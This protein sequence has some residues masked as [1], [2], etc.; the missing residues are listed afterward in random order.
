MS[1]RIF[2]CFACMS[3]LVACGDGQPLFDEGTGGGTGGGNGEELPRTVELPPGTVNTSAGRGIERYEARNDLGGGLITND[4]VSYD[5]VADTFTVD[6]LAFDG[7]N[8]YR[9]DNQVPVLNGFNVYEASVQVIDPVSGEPVGQIVPYRALVGQSTN[10]VNGSPRTSFAI[11]RTGGYADYGF[12]GFVYERNG[13]VV[14]PT[15]GQATFSGDYAGMRVFLGQGGLE[16]TTGDM[17]IDIDFDDFNANDGVKGTITNR[18]AFT[19]NGQPIPTGGD[20]QLVLPTLNFVIVEGATTLDSSGEI[21]GNLNSVNVDDAGNREIY[22]SGTYYGILS[23]DMRDSSDGGEIV[24]VIVI[25]SEDPRFQG[26]QAQ[27]TGGFVL[28]R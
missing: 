9:R 26:V 25:E 18:E 21:S 16:Y 14:L 2:A 12:G 20:D 15:S 24:G 22:E 19:V 28:Y 3:I 27:E 5:P 1:V 10:T 7:E 17:T 11:V 8:V 4:Q 13:N 23:G 6:N